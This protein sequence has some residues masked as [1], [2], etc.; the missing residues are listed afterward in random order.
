M[1]SVPEFPRLEAANV[2]TGFF[3]P[4]DFAAVLAELP[5]PLKAPLE[6]AYLT[7]WRV[8]SEVL[9]LT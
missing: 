7:G 2:R 9:P 8:P 1:P 6:F 3:E 5:E 4:A